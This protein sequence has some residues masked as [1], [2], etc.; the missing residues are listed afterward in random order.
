M[1]SKKPSQTK[2]RDWPALD[3]AHAR[4]GALITI[5][6][7]PDGGAYAPPPRD[8]RACRP[9]VYSDELV[10]A[11][12]LAKAVTG[13]SLRA[14][15]GFARGLRELVGGEW[16]VPDY[17]TLSLR[18]RTL[19]VDIDARLKAGRHLFMVDSTGLKV[20]GE[21]EWK[22]RTHGTDGKRRTWRKIHLL[23][24]RETGHV[25]AVE[26]TDNN[27]NDCL[28]LPALLPARLDGDALLG[29]GA[30]HTKKAH[31]AVHDKGGLLLTPPKVGARRWGR[32]AT[33]NDEAAFVFRNQQVRAIGMLGRPE[34]KLRSG[35]SRRSFVESTM[36]RLK[37]I[38]GDRLAAR[39]RDRQLVEVRV[40]C[41]AL[42][43]LAT[44]TVSF[45]A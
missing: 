18:Q 44:S 36:R 43:A 20:F 6:L 7:S 30:Y 4:R 41:K 8:G 32:T 42:N 23:V 22:V 13:L 1:S 38:T 25:A 26:M 10:E 29:D 40:R 33:S 27:V 39:T 45:A 12:F 9:R 11:L 37:A 3:A 28:V 21:G 15:E 34:W 2:K 24:D 19:K 16:K 31:R 5:V 35:Y 14:L 17:S